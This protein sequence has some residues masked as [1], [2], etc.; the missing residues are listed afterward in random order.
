MKRTKSS[1]GMD[2]N[3]VVLIGAPPAARGRQA[4]S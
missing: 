3:I 4:I 2:L 1:T